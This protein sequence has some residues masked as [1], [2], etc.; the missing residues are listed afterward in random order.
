MEF[1]KELLE[2]LACPK[3]KG[4]LKLTDPSDGLVCD[5]CKL[6][7]PIRDGIPIMLMNEA[8]DL[9]RTGNTP[10]SI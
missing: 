10:K 8:E 3:C 6:K 9:T 5:A 7:Y 1:D 4:D 2:F